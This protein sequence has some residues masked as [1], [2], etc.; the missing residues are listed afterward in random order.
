[1]TSDD[2]NK[3]GFAGAK[4]KTVCPYQKRFSTKDS[5]SRGN[6]AYDLNKLG[7]IR[8]F[9]SKGKKYCSLGTYFRRQDFDRSPYDLNNAGFAGSKLCRK[10][11]E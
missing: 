6:S 2:L 3:A 5:S 9:G 7:G 1:M 11:L 8:N 10:C 4:K